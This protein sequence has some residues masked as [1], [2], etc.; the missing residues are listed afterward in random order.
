MFVALGL[1]HDDIVMVQSIILLLYVHLGSV[2]V[3]FTL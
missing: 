2:Q 3:G 1:N